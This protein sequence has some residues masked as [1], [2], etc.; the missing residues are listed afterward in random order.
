MDGGGGSRN[1]GPRGNRRVRRTGAV[2]LTLFLTTVVLAF[3]LSRYHGSVP[4]TAV[5][6]LIGGGTLLA[7][8]LAWTTYRDSQTKGEALAFATVADEPAT[9]VS[10]QWEREAAIDAASDDPAP[11]PVRW[12][13]SDPPISEEWEALVQSGFQR[14]RL[15]CP[16]RGMGGRPGRAGG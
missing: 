11:L 15:A 10:N 5:T 16:G 13:P 7:L 3:L 4:E 9:A 8:Y 14:C 2:A 1:W 6:I 12:L